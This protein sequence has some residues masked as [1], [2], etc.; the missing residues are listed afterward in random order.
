MTHTQELHAARMRLSSVGRRLA[1]IQKS[2][3]PP[4][5]KKAARNKV[6]CDALADLRFLNEEKLRLAGWNYIRRIRG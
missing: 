5:E 2:N 1:E 3:L 4:A 6:W